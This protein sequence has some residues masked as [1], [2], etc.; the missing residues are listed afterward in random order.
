LKIISSAI[1]SQLIPELDVDMS[2]IPGE[3]ALTSAFS[4]SVLPMALNKPNSALLFETVASRKSSLCKLI[5][6]I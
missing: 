4:N 2:T 1:G 6:D 5:Y 3:K